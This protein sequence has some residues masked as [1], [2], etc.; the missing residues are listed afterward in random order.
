MGKL[1]DAE[2]AESYELPGAGLSR[3]SL[4]V[5]VTPKQFN[6]FTCTA[7]FFV[8]QDSHG[9]HRPQTSVAT[10]L[11]I[12]AWRRDVQPGPDFAAQPPE[13]SCASFRLS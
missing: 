9:P 4:S 8:R 5:E 1:D 13:P 12:D 2:L 10:R 3:K 6:E 7:C 11:T